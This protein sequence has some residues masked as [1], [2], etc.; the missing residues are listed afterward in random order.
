MLPCFQLSFLTDSLHVYLWK[1][2]SADMPL[3]D[4]FANKKYR[5]KKA[6]GDKLLTLLSNY[7]GDELSSI[8]H[9]VISDRYEISY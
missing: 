5:R 9:C 7:L 1:L 2:S 3:K 4:Q 6:F 8:I